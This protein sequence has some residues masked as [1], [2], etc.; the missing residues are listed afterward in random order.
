[1]NE[2]VISASSIILM[3]NRIASHINDKVKICTFATC[4]FFKIVLC[5]LYIKIGEESLVQSRR[6]PA[7]VTYN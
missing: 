6:S 5:T 7:K 1:V 3:S 2:S 4:F